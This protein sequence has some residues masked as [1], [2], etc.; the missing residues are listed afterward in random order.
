MH[1]SE[2]ILQ[3]EAFPEYLQNIK[4]IHDSIP[5]DGSQHESRIRIAVECR[6]VE[7]LEQLWKDYCSGYLNVVAEK[8]LLTDDIKERFQVESVNLQTT[9]FQ[10]DYLACKEF[11]K[12]KTRK[13]VRRWFFLIYGEG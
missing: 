11:L 6:N 2:E 5:T 1:L 8:C 7:V 4:V 3:A 13:L 12:N 9:I 10:E